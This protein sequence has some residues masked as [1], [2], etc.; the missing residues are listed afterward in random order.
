MKRRG[1]LGLL[2]AVLPSAALLPKVVLDVPVPAPEKPKE[3]D[4]ARLPQAAYSG[5]QIEGEEVIFE[6]PERRYSNSNRVLK[7][8]LSWAPVVPGTLRL[9]VNGHNIASDVGGLPRSFKIDY[10][11]GE[12]TYYSFGG[13]EFVGYEPHR[14]RLHADYKY[15]MS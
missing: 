4:R 13:I 6:L 5:A 7:A 3:W 2:A 9:H 14:L 10:E 15:A 1:V 11:T 12:L 8:Q